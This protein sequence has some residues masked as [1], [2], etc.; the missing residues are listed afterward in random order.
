M[1]FYIL[2][3]FYGMTALLRSKET[4]EDTYIK[5]GMSKLN[6]SANAS[7][8]TIPEVPFAFPGEGSFGAIGSNIKTLGTF[9]GGNAIQAESAKYQTN[10]TLSGMNNSNQNSSG[11]TV[12]PI[13]VAKQGETIDNISN[14]YGVS[15]KEILNSNKWLQNKGIKPGDKVVI[16]KQFDLDE[17]RKL[18]ARMPSQGILGDPSVLFSGKTFQTQSNPLQPK[19]VLNEIEDLR[20]FNP[21]GNVV[22]NLNVKLQERESEIKCSPQRK[23][24]CG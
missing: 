24:V 5:N 21:Y 13:H 16:P 7:V 18:D 4:K 17:L 14:K 9:F 20:N 3:G 22:A 12:K 6:A 2:S 1:W 15:K 11:I 23:R 10:R 8:D 19:G